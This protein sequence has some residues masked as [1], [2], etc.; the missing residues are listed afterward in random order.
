MRSKC[1]TGT[2]NKKGIGIFHST[3]TIL[4]LQT[5]SIRENNPVLY[6]GPKNYIQRMK[7]SP[8]ILDVAC[9]VNLVRGLIS[10]LFRMSAGN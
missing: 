9:N 4:I 8:V 3:L 7:L 6:L 5:R 1:D 10:S 2:Y